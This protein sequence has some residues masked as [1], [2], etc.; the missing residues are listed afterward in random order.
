MDVFQVFYTNGQSEEMELEEL[1]EASLIRG[2]EL[3]S[4]KPWVPT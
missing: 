4:T 1:Q 3:P 2:C